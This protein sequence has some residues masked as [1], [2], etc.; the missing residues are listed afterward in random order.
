M[1][2]PLTRRQLKAIQ[3]AHLDERDIM[4]LLRE[5]RRLREVILALRSL[6]VRMGRSGGAELADLL[7]D[8]AELIDQEP[9]VAELE[10]DDRVQHA[11]SIDLKRSTMPTRPRYR[12]PLG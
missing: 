3:E 9:C 11:S 6:H 1:A 4:A 10:Y 8:A 5:I 2:D 7:T 12:G